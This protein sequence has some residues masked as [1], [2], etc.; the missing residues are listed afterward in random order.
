MVKSGDVLII[1]LHLL[2]NVLLALRNVLLDSL[3]LDKLVSIATLLPKRTD[4]EIKSYKNTHL[5]KRLD[6][7]G[8]DPVT[9]KPKNDAL[10]RRVPFR[11]CCQPHPHG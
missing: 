9:H 11:E 1:N 4:N 3:N 6:K 10:L 2:R 7:M 8:I 5:K